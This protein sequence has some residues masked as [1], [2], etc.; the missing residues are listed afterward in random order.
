MNV[1]CEYIS[2]LGLLDMSFAIFLKKLFGKTKVYKE[3]FGINIQAS[4]GIHHD[5]IKLE[6][7]K[8]PLG[9]M[10]DLEYG[11]KLDGDIYDFLDLLEPLK[12]I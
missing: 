6:I 10:D 4:L 9:A 11:Q 8:S 5:I 12:F 1:S 3:N 7:I 2:S